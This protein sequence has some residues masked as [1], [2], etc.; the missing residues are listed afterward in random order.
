LSITP[1]KYFHY[2]SPI[3]ILKISGDEEGILAIDFQ[4]KASSDENDASEVVKDCVQQ[5]DEYFSGKRI[6]FSVPL[7][8]E[9]TDF[10]S[11]SGVRFMISPM[12]K[13]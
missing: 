11:A 12:E 13:H 6:S 9:G 7:K 4:D 3:G 10:Q 2:H 1:L 5:L 8:I